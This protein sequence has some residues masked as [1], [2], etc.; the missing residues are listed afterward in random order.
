MDLIPALFSNVWTIA[1]IVLFFGGS[2]F[3]HELGHFLAARQRG[4]HVSRFSIGFGPKIFAWTGRDGVEYRL[5]WL[6]LGGYVALPQLADMRGVEGESDAPAERL[7]PISYTT[8]MIVFAA[9]AAFNFIFAFLLATIIWLVGQPTTS[10][11]VTTQIG[12]VAPTITLADGTQIVS[13]AVEAG[14]QVGDRVV[15]LDGRRLRDWQDLLQTLVTSAGR[16]EGGRRFNVFTVERDGAEIDLTVYPGIATD[17]RIRRVGIAPAYTLV[18]RDVEPDSAAATAGLAVGDRL[19]NLLDLSDQLRTGIGGEFTTVIDR[20]GQTLRLPLVLPA[21]AD[22]QPADF[23]LVLATDVRLVH[24]T[25]TEQFSAHV[26]MTFRTLGSLLNPQSDIGLSKLSGPVGIVRV[27]HLA[28]QAD[29]RLVIWFTILVNINLAIFNLLPIPVLDGGHMV[30][31]TLAKLRGKALP[32]SFIMGTQS[33]FM[34]LLFSMILY[35]TFFDVRRIV[36]DF[37]PPPA[38]QDATPNQ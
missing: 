19:L 26:G 28:A 9:G 4:V 6:P 14:L 32:S 24:P 25:P 38:S 21:D 7:A 10:D 29:I 30:F 33:V 11:Q 15:A 2:I 16:T 31:A 27:F 13:P 37:T 5:S 1:L 8:K 22:A 36:R 18:V 12:N 34:A 20:A 17:E 35:V 23:G 3:V